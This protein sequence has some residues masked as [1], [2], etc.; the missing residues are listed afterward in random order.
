[1]H[2]ET[3]RK[4]TMPETK[5]ICVIGASGVV[6]SHVC[7]TALR[8]GYK[9]RTALDFQYTILRTLSNIQKF[10]KRLKKLLKNW[11]KISD[12]VVKKSLR[13]I[14]HF[15]IDNM[16]FGVMIVVEFYSEVFETQKFYN[17]NSGSLRFL[18]HGKTRGTLITFKW[19][20]DNIKTFKFD[21]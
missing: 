13:K 20:T 11:K 2:E 19:W 14:L 21:F 15:W 1:M 6:G 12:S 9:V 4:N 18:L 8:K 7:Q 10:Q 5:R 17:I 16:S 3:L